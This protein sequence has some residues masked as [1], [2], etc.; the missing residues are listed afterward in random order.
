M[1]KEKFTKGPWVYEPVKSNDNCFL[2]EKES[3]GFG[4]CKTILNQDSDM[5]NANL[6]AAAPEMYSILEEIMI[7]DLDGGSLHRANLIKKLLEKA[8]GEI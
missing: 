3:T 7:D 8:R 2:I 6:I 5:A 4:V 1:S